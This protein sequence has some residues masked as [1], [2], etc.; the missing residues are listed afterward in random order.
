MKLLKTA[1]NNHTR[2][3]TMCFNESKL[4][5]ESKNYN[6]KMVDKLA[7]TGTKGEESL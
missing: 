5:N 2:K 1:I 3:G 4:N 7:K 6:N